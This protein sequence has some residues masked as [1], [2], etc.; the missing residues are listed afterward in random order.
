MLSSTHIILRFVMTSEPE[1]TQPAVAAEEETPQP[2]QLKEPKGASAFARALYRR[3][4]EASTAGRDEECFSILQKLMAE[5]PGDDKVAGYARTIGKRIYKTAAA[6]IPAV[7]EGGNLAKITQL[8]RKLRLM[9][10][11]SELEGLV[12]YRDA[13]AR[14]DEAER[15]YWQS[16]LISAMGKM[17]SASELRVREDM[18]VSIEIFAQEKHLNFTPEQAA[19]LARVHEDWHRFCRAEKLRADYNKQHDAFRAI[20]KKIAASEDLEQCEQELHVRHLE[21]AKL[22]ELHE[23]TELM[24]LIEEQQA[25]VRAILTAQHRRRVL[26][27]TAI[28]VVASIILLT[29]AAFVFAYARAGSLKDNLATGMAEKKVL[30]VSELVGGID[31]MRGFCKSVHGGY[32][33]ALAQA[34]AWLKVYNGY[35]GEI[36]ALTPELS[37]ATDMLTNP[38]VS[39]AELTGGLVLVDKVRQVEDKL[40]AEYNTTAAKEASI[41]MG[42][43]YDRLAEIRPKVLNRFGQPA[44]DADMEALKALYAEFRSCDKLLNVTKEEDETVCCAM[45]AAAARVLHALSRSSLEPAVAQ[46][47]VDTF[48]SYAEVLPLLPSLREE[49]VA[50]TNRVNALAA[51]PETLKSVKDLE[52]FAAALEHCGDC[53]ESV[54]NAVSAA[55]VR[56]LIGKEDAAMRAHKLA[57]F[58]A[59]QSTPIAPEQIL[60]TLQT[61]K[62]MYADGESVYKLGR[63]EKI[64]ALIDLMLSDRNNLWKNGLRRAVQDSSVYIGT[65]SQRG[66]NAVMTL[67]NGQGLPSRRRV[68]LREAAVKALTP[69]VLSGQRKVMGFERSVLEAGGITPA[70][71]MHNI[72]SKADPNCP[73][74]ARAY[75][76][77]LA[78]RMAE[79]L[80][81]FSSG[82]AFSESMRQ[83]IEA[84][85]A[86]IAT[87]SLYPGCWYIMHAAALDARWHEFFERVASRDYY[88]EILN[89]V[90]PITDSRCTYAGYVNTEGKAVRCGSEDDVLYII[91]DGV[92]VPYADTPERAYTPLF[93]VTLPQK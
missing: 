61:V 6:E 10:D 23:A 55:D 22:R 52:A 43:F 88:A 76:F 25:K 19:I 12:G 13:A 11:E 42:K 53:Y 30:E 41:L 9:A 87:S 71:L 79:R 83:D 82:L 56:A 67:S 8:V 81:A 64:D 89:A 91:K 5:N 31:P 26:I 24:T 45:Q 35:Q 85:K 57:D 58:Q 29:I 65:V 93:K 59:V 63:P 21:T 70:R 62:A 18:A 78:I 15:K 66:K 68:N 72:A 44:Q 14:V 32:A 28:C 46:K 90:L 39:A 92:I 34:D 1:E 51:L 20:E 80:D 73:E 7:L 74:L 84:Y 75:M 40:K 4:N 77:G 49:L 54:P 86:I 50:R 48:D 38:S 37:E 16:M 3:F 69:V 60:P 17:R 47:A 33:D 27:R 36:A 2:I